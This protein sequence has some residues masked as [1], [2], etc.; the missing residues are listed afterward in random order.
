M[1]KTGPFTITMS[2]T[3]GP[4]VMLFASS[5]EANS[6]IDGKLVQPANAQVPIPLQQQTPG[7]VGANGVVDLEAPSGTQALL[8]GADGVNSL[9]AACWANFAGIH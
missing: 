1:V 3:S 6:V 5:S 7:N 2:C 4:D 9:G 8:A